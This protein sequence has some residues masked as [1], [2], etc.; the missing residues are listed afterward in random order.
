[1]MKREAKGPQLRVKKKKRKKKKKR[2]KKRKRKNKCP[3]RQVT[4]IDDNSICRQTLLLQQRANN[5]TRNVILLDLASYDWK[6]IEKRE[7]AIAQ[8]EKPHEIASRKK[9]KC[10]F[11]IPTKS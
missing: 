11:N 8:R 4:I 9:T 5:S 7:I 10:I 1:M 2:R 3:T 6:P